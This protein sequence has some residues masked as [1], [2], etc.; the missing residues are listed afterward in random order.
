M[1]IACRGHGIITLQ[2]EVLN[3]NV[4][5]TAGKIKITEGEFK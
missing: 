4:Y 1:P 3:E 5:R 2:T